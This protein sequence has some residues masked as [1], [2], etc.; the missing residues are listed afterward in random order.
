MFMPGCRFGIQA[1]ASDR[2]KCADR[3]WL[4]LAFHRS[5]ERWLPGR[6]L[7]P[8]IPAEGRGKGALDMLVLSNLVFGN[9]LA[10]YVSKQT[11]LKD[12]G[13]PFG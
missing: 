13:V 8:A 6:V 3:T 11:N 2:H 9:E 10:G 4:C 12:S 5:K 7:L 1:F